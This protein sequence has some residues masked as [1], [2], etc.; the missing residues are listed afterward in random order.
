[1]R[2]AGRTSTERKEPSKKGKE[3][4]VGHE[5]GATIS[6]RLNLWIALSTA[7]SS[8]CASKSEMRRESRP[9]LRQRKREKRARKERIKSANRKTRLRFRQSLDVDSDGSPSSQTERRKRRANEAELSERRARGK[10]DKNDGGKQRTRPSRPNLWRVISSALLSLPA[11]CGEGEEPLTSAPSRETEGE[12]QERRKAPEKKGKEA[13]GRRPGWSRLLVL[14]SLALS[15]PDNAR[16]RD[17]ER[18]RER[19]RETRT[20][21]RESEERC[22]RR[23]DKPEE[24][25]EVGRGKRVSTSPISTCNPALLSLTPLSGSTKKES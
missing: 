2:E 12:H 9:E 19:E 3:T 13:E 11:S 5:K 20:K 15:A 6:P 24:R 16:A 4:D 21:R 18:E 8:L 17:R 14:S 23:T 25:S 1:M 7:L 22:T 10:R